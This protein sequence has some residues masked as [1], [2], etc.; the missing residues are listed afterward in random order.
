MRLFRRGE[1]SWSPPEPRVFLGVGCAA[2]ELPAMFQVAHP[3]AADGS[4]RGFPLLRDDDSPPGDL[5]E[6]GRPMR[7][8]DSFVV[9]APEQ[10]MWEVLVTEAGSFPAP[11][12][13][14]WQPA[15][16]ETEFRRRVVASR[17]DVFVRL[18]Q[19][20]SPLGPVV[21]FGM[22]LADRVAVLAEGAIQDPQTY[23]AFGPGGWR[24]DDPLD[25]LD[26]RE[27]VTL[28]VVGEGDEPRWI[29]THGLVKFGRP[30]FE[31]YDVPPELA[32]AAAPGF[33]D[34]AGHVMRGALVEPGQTVGD[35]AVP[36]GVQIGGRNR[37]HWVDSPVLELVDVR[38]GVRAKRGAEVGLRAW[39]AGNDR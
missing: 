6:L 20:E 1:R 4:L 34:L 23:R 11:L 10:G 25:E 15:G 27:H 21:L 29:H 37:L 8:G 36:I 16:A 24:V 17:F 35:P 5:R 14:F 7:V 3:E 38:D 9:S 2:P 39:L 12:P 32:G 13:E 31:V 22:E 30:E 18:L 33:L 26:P 19:P 28:H